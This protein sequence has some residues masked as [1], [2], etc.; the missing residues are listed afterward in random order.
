MNQNRPKVHI[1]GNL[2]GPLGRAIERVLA[3]EGTENDWRNS[4]TVPRPREWEE[5]PDLIGKTVIPHTCNAQVHVADDDGC[6]CNLIGKFVKITGLVESLFVGTP[7]YTIEGS[8]KHIQEQEFSD[9]TRGVDPD[10]V[11]GFVLEN[12]DGKFLSA[13]F[14]WIAQ[15]GPSDGYLHNWQAARELVSNGFPNGVPTR[16]YMAR[17]TLDGKEKSVSDQPIT[18]EMLIRL[19]LTL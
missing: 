18:Y 2:E 10:E 15:N 5:R 7:S 8:T 3:D 9:E 19:V 6:I 1:E 16:V 4:I 17:Q 13:G 12:A 11:S 14:V